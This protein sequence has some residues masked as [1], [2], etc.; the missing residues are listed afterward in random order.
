M[1]RGNHESREMTEM[2]NFREQCIQMYDEEFYEKVM[3]AFDLLPV[4]AIV[5]GQYLCMHG[6]ISDVLTSLEAINGIDRKQEP[7]DQDCLLVD[8]LWADP[9][10]NR[11]TDIDYKF[12]DK[13]S[14]SVIFGKRP[15]NKLLQ[16]EGLKSIIRAHECKQRGYKFH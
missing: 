15:V 7:P 4:S 6:G 14:V 13:R 3:E 12:N 5:N 11:E 2:F 9:T 1:L 10:R 16:K 8:L